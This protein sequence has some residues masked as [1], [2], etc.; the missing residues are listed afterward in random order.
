MSTE[1]MKMHA[2]LVAGVTQPSSMWSQSRN[3]LVEPP[4]QAYFAICLSVKDQNEDLREWLTH[5][6]Q[7]GAGKFYIM[8]DMSVTHVADS[9]TDFIEDGTGS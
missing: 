4:N 5:H 1:N 6:H 9:L 8:D 3:A 2:L 7:I